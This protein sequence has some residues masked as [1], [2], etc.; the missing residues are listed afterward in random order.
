M[1]KDKI[2]ERIMKSV[3]ANIISETPTQIALNNNKCGLY[4]KSPRD[5]TNI[6]LIVEQIKGRPN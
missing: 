2:N 4:L 6:G 5:A 3:K 1:I